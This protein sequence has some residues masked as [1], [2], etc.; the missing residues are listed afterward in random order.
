MKINPVY[1][2]PLLSGLYKLWHSLIRYEDKGEWQ[3]I[4]DT[5]R[6][7]QPAVIAMWHNE[8][9][10]LSG[11]GS[12]QESNYI[13]M[14]SQ[15]RDGELI[16]GIIESLGHSTARGS[17]SRGGLRALL[18]LVKKMKKNGKVGV[19]TVDGPRGPRHQVKEGV[20]F[21]AQRAK[22]PIFPVRAFASRKLV[23]NSWDRFEVPYPFSRCRIRV[24]EPFTV[25][26]EKLTSEVMEQEKKRL[27]FALKSIT[28][29]T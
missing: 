7:G 15:S 12:R 29:D 6:A 19:F 1:F 3:P 10:P 11:F 4:V 28:N 23:F 14:V 8:L 20:I 26:G 13:I 25:T 21:A 16:A 18:T 2:K 5:I 9:F 17:S 27:K 24:G 22:A